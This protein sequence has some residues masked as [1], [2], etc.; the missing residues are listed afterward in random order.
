MHASFESEYFMFLIYFLYLP[1][2]HMSFLCHPPVPPKVEIRGYDNNWYLGRTNAVLT[3]EAE[4]NPVAT[5]VE[6]KT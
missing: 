6:W 2:F 3:C 4:A 1:F 5:F